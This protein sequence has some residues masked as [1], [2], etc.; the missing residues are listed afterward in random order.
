MT[1]TLQIEEPQKLQQ[2]QFDVE[3]ISELQQ[4]ITAY[5]TDHDIYERDYSLNNVSDA[6][7][8]AAEEKRNA[9]LERVL[10]S[11]VV[12]CGMHKRFLQ[13]YAAL[14]SAYN[15][16]TPIAHMSIASA[17]T[18]QTVDVEAT[19]PETSDFIEF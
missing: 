1:P 6:E 16:L 11:L 15:I 19:V 13:Q 10:S 3:Q 9:T 14:Q 17:T 4:V 12:A 18:V 7:M 8:E 5:L 2:I